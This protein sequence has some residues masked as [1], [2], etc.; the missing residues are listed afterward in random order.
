MLDIKDLVVEHGNMRALFGMTLNVRQGERVALLGANGAGKSTTLGAIAGIYPPRSGSIR[1]KGQEIA[2][3]PAAINVI[4]GIAMVPEGRRLFTGMTVQENLELGAYAPSLR[5]GAHDRLEEIFAMFPILKEK[6]HQ[7]SGELSGGQQQMVAIGR[8]LMSKPDLLLLDE[9]FL[10]IAPVVVHLVMDALRKIADGG[11]T[12][13][14]V[15]QNVHRAFEFAERGYVI[16]HGH[17]IMQGSAHDILDDPEF[18]AKF[19]GVDQ[20]ENP[21]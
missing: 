4:N 5:K 11:V 13:L 6:R 17:V 1:F 8:A 12:V 15:E 14:L 21:S 9:P 3:R 10:G 16:E 18:S 20:V 7:I 2:G 19:L